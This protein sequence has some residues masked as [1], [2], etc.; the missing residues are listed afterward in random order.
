MSL[1]GIS[2]EL[3]RTGPPRILLKKGDVVLETLLLSRATDEHRSF[4]I[5]TWVKSYESQARRHGIK[6]F[7]VRHEPAVAERLWDQCTVVTDDTGYTVHAWVCANDRGQLWH[8]YVIPTLRQLR[9]AT[10]LIEYACPGGLK[11]YARPWPYS[12]HAPVNPYLLGG[13]Q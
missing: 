2:S 3:C 4:I 9:L 10:R 5:S 13:A 7:Y 11:E 6:N 1:R 8:C 12:A